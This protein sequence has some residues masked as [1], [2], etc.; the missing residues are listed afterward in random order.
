MKVGGWTAYLTLPYP[1]RSAEGTTPER[2]E[3]GWA[4]WTDNGE[5]DS[6][7]DISLMTLIYCSN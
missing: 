7:D 1:T 6:A 2:L 3:I 5:L 4:V